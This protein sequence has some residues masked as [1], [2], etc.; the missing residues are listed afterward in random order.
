V[1][2]LLKYGYLQVSR[3]TPP[4]FQRTTNEC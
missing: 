2:H 4:V 1:L 3:E